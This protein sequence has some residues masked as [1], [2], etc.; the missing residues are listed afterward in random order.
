MP[1]LP[2]KKSVGPSETSEA[3][4]EWYIWFIIGVAFVL[5]I[6]IIT[7]IFVCWKKQIC[8]FKKNT[9]ANKKITIMNTV[10]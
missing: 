1:A 9:E 7:A 2:S 8:L 10:D 4:I 5:L 3:S 6:G